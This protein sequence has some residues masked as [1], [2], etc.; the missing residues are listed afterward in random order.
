MKAKLQAFYLWLRAQWR[1]LPSPV[2]AAI[3]GIVMGFLAAV[4]HA[5]ESGGCMTG[6]CLKS[7]AHSAISIGVSSIWVFYM[8]PSGGP[9]APPAAPISALPANAIGGGNAI[10]GAGSGVTH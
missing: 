6:V 5:Y 2:Q 3:T 1:R 9:P 7:Y 4:V 10:G 8:K